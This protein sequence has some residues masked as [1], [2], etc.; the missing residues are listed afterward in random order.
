MTNRP[1]IQLDG[2]S[3]IRADAII[4]FAPCTKSTGE[5]LVEV[6]VDGAIYHVPTK[7]FEEATAICRSLLSRLTNIVQLREA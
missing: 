4:G 7:T 5:H 1:F 6:F 2:A 3:A